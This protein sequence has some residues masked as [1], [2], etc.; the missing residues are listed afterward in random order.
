V[1]DATL[2]FEAPP[3]DTAQQLLADL[4]KA[5]DFPALSHVIS[6]VNRFSSSETSRTNDLTEAILK[7][8]ALTNKLLRIVNSAHFGSFG[9]RPINTISRAIV[10]L[11]F[12]TVRDVALSLMLFEH[13]DNHAQASELKA[14]AVESF[15]CG[16]LGRSL[17][18]RAGVRDTEEVL[19]CALFRN[20]GRMICRLHFYEK[21]K[22]VEALMASADLSEETASRRV[23]GLSYDEFGQ[24]LGRHWHLPASLLQGMAPLPPGAVKAP[25]NE[26]GKTQLLANMAHEVYL[27]TKHTAPEALEQAVSAL[28]KKY[29]AGVSF[30]A[31]TLLEVVQQSAEA[32]QEEARSIG[33]DIKASPLV[34]RLVEEGPTP[35]L[36]AV[37]TTEADAALATAEVTDDPTSI[38]VAGIQDLTGM[39]LEDFRP[40]ELLQVAAELLYRAKCFD[41]VLI[42]TIAASGKELVGR[43][44][45]GPKAEV[46][47]QVVRIPLGF[48]PDV[49]HAAVSKGVDLLISDTQ[50]DNIKGRIPAWYSDRIGAKSFLL[51]PVQM[52]G[53]TVALLY[54]DRQLES[55]QLAPQTLGLIKALRN[56]IALALR[57]KHQA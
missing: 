7:D 35:V 55:M 46:L 56:Q 5:Q 15:F 54:G 31:K 12:N 41:H 8:V 37:E 42:S 14:E 4:S 9:G 21:G 51:L 26:A 52:G 40:A 49:F 50:A 18:G 16:L 43:I 24:A 53:R 3:P 32:I 2:D 57:Q 48:A 34:Q 36:P 33:M 10:I 13:L 1:T 29:G 23:F 22:E 25:G 47:K 30:P 6:Q 17:A 28:G 44:G 39:L 11:G 19:I 45:F 20:L 38:L 27:T